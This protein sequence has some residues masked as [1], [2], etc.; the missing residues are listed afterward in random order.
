MSGRKT[1]FMS[2]GR[3]DMQ[4][5]ESTRKLPAYGEKESGSLK[6]IEISIWPLRLRITKNVFINTLTA[7]GGPKG[8]SILYWTQEGTW[9]V[10]IRKRLRLL[11][12]SLLATLASL[13]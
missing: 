13:Y 8:I 11:M 10:G 1:V 7:R 9:P 4:L 5:E 12:S 6:P 3:R 2:G